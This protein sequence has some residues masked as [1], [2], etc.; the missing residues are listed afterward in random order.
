MMN[1]DQLK[2]RIDSHI[3][4]PITW[5]DDAFM[6]SMRVSAQDV[7]QVISSLYHHEELNFKFLTDLTGVHFPERQGEEFEVVYHLH[8]LVDNIRLKIKVAL[9]LE[10]PHIPSIVDIYNGANWME[11]ET[12]DFFGIIFDN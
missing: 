3:Q 10:H 1:I 11:R 8:N 5:L 2:S 7:H 4:A 9:P 6:P 12:F